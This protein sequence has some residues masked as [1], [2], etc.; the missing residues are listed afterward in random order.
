MVNF[1][2]I[3]ST[4]E[5]GSGKCVVVNEDQPEYMVMTWLEYEKMVDT[6]HKLS[7]GEDIDIAD[8]PL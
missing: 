6:I 1:D 2:T 7:G 4:L 3:K 5:Q 8:I